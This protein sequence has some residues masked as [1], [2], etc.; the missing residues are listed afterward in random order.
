MPGQSTFARD[1][2]PPRPK[3]R[4]GGLPG[5][6]SP[7]AVLD[8]AELAYDTGFLYGHDM[9]EN[10]LAPGQSPP[11]GVAQAFVN[12]RRD[13]ASLPRYPGQPPLDLVAAYQIQDEALVLDGRAVAG[14]KVG[15]IP[16]P[17][18]ERL[19]ANRL[20][21]PILAGTVVEEQPGVEAQMRAFTGGFIAVEAEFMLRLRVPEHGTLPE[22]D[23]ATREWID[24]V[25]IGI[26]I[27][28]SP[29]AAINDQGPCVTI[30]DFGN[31]AGVLLG[32]SITGWRDRDLSAILVTTEID[33]VRVASA[34]AATMLDGPL[35]AL[36]FLL[37]HLQWRGIAPQSGWWI[38]SGA[39]TGV[40]TANI[41]QHAVVT[42]AGVGSLACRVVAAKRGSNKL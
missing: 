15:R 34:T 25:R 41:G 2:K 29:F 30:S 9:G 1:E 35:G 26:E 27:A 31:N 10:R 37:K 13:D 16:D 20:V 11:V 36:R 12:A 18:A 38:S 40:H 39:V 6:S 42:F 22:D 23:T 33:G 32:S 17:D 4:L 8:P 7:G 24:T 21:G 28:S 3:P 19:G 14:W 5:V